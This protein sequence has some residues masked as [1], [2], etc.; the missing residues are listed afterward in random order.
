MDLR[1]QSFNCLIAT[2]FK[3][4]STS[5]VSASRLKHRESDV[6]QRRFWEHAIKNQ[7]DLHQYLD[8]IHYNPVK[9]GLVSCPHL[10]SY[11][12][13]SKWV[14]QGRYAQDWGCI[15]GGKSWK[16]FDFK[17]ISLQVGE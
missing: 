8:Y 3:L 15:C 13:F 9:H 11:S 14:N 4:F 7:A 10:W 2:L 1:R 12:S 6:W 16:P 5:E 17:R